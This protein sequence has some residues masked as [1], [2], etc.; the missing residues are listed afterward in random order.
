MMLLGVPQQ[1]LVDCTSALPAPRDQFP[2]A[3]LPLSAAPPAGPPGA[4]TGPP[5]G[6][7]TPPKGF[8]EPPRSGE[9]GRPSGPRGPRP[10]APGKNIPTDVAAA[11]YIAPTPAAAKA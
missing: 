3:N 7:P 8:P 2:G 5:K 10:T 9:P 4:P 1:G 6:A 11:G